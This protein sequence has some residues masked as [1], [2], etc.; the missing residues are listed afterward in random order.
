MNIE[1]YRE[2]F[3]YEFDFVEIVE[4]N[5]DD[6]EE[7]VIIVEYMDLMLK[8]RCLKIYLLKIC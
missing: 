5:F 3:I 4:D 1:F 6:V 8:R 7:E 2:I